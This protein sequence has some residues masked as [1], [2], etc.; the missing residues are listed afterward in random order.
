MKPLRFAKMSGA[1]NDFILVDASSSRLPTAAK[2]AKDL[3]RRQSG[4]GAD[5]LLLMR[6]HGRAGIPSVDYYNADGSKA[7]CGNGT[8]CAAWWAYR[9]RWTGRQ[10][11]LNTLSGAVAAEIIAPERVRIAMPLPQ[12]ARF[13]MRLTAEGR[14]LKAHYV[15]IGVP[16]AVV[17]VSAWDSFPVVRVGRAVRY[18]SVFRPQGVNVDFMLK[19]KASTRGKPLPI[20]TYERGVEDE[21]LACGTGTVASAFCAHYFYGI[22]SPV[23]IATRGGDTLTVEFKTKEGQL[24]EVWLEGP[25]RITFQGEF[26]L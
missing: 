8:R 7:F 23:R 24:R 2:L 11:S 21:T 22:P 19:P 3:C 12:H 10:F 18:H 13:N 25:A 5:G 14:S 26:A 17:E 15:E 6:R 9:Q 20:R 1:G 16:H 4:V